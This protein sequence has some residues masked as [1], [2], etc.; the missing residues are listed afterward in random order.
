MIHL[1]A[2]LLHES[3]TPF[4]AN[5]DSLFSKLIL[6]TGTRCRY[7]LRAGQK[8]TIVRILTSNGTKHDEEDW[9]EEA[10]REHQHVLVNNGGQDE[11][12]HSRHLTILNKLKR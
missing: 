6:K 12:R 4:L 10:K 9:V 2:L 7:R 11:H 1:S 5:Q 8:Q 3:K